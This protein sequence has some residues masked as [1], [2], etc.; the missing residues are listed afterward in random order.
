MFIKFRYLFKFAFLIINL[1][2]I[3][4]NRQCAFCQITE[5]DPNRVL[6][7]DD[8]IIIF[9][10]RSPV[11]DI[12]LQCIPKSHIKNKNYLTKNELNLLNHMYI[13]ARNFIEL[14]YKDRL[15]NNTPI[16]GFHKPPFYTIGHLHMHCIIP[17]YTN[18]IME[19]LNYCILKDFNDVIKEIREKE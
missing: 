19:T 15:I 7:E 10:D 8:Q 14:N 3:M 18:K 11:A 2:I 17:P 16:F 5:T 9:K 4:G 6:Y 1:K 12:H 13:A